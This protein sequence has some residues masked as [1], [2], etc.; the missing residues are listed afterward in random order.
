MKTIAKKE[1]VS[2]FA[3]KHFRIGLIT[4]FPKSDNSDLFVQILGA[5]CE[6][7]FV[8]SVLALGDEKIQKELMKISEKYIGQ[9]EILESTPQNEKKIILQSDVILFLFKPEKVLLKKIMKKGVV[10]IVPFEKDLTN[11][12]AQAEVGNAFC[13]TEGNYWEV[14]ATVVRAF[15]N[16][17]FAYDWGNLKKSVKKSTDK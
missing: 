10:P 5:M 12:D 7:G 2:K 14:F 3:T 9:F 13:F 4:T 11:F 17:K 1:T 15:E 6:L 16:Y 8:I